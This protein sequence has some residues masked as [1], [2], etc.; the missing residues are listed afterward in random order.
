MSQTLVDTD[1]LIPVLPEQSK[2]MMRSLFLLPI[3]KS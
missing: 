3:T 1:I 2:I